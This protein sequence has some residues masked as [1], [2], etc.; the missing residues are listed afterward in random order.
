MSWLQLTDNYLLLMKGGSDQYIDRV[1]IDGQKIAEFPRKW[2]TSASQRPRTMII[3]LETTGDDIPSF[4]EAQNIQLLKKFEVP[5]S[6]QLFEE[7]KKRKT[8]LE[9]LDLFKK[10]LGDF[11]DEF[12]EYNDELSQKT[13]NIQPFG[14]VA[15]EEVKMINKL[16]FPEIDF[17]PRD[18]DFSRSTPSFASIFLEVLR[19]ANVTV[20]PRI[21][22]YLPSDSKITVSLD[23]IKQ[24]DPNRL[25][26]VVP[27]STLEKAVK[28][29]R[30][31]ATGEGLKNVDG[32]LKQLK[33][34]REIVVNSP[35]LGSE[36]DLPYLEGLL[37]FTDIMD[38]MASHYAA[39]WDWVG[40]RAI[41]TKTKITA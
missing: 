1:K 16:N 22:E 21:A 31:N 20:R 24:P 4:A 41:L 28:P 34:E 7:M 27:L 11:T 32:V 14:F 35:S 12:F 6:F 3:G 13:L 19:Q 40:D 36:R 25:S 17:D 10:Q 9:L 39:F 23:F 8:I 29:K 33:K 5:I 37:T 18:P 38:T 2:F 26:S 30:F 15:S